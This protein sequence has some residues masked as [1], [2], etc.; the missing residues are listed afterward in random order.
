M[1]SKYPD[2]PE[3]QAALLLRVVTSGEKKSL[4][5]SDCIQYTKVGLLQSLD[6]WP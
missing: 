1:L 3:G 2:Y 4:W 6:K 5:F